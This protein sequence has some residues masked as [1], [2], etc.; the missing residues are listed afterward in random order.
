MQSPLTQRA[1]VATPHAATLRLPTLLRRIAVGL[2]GLAAT[3]GVVLFLNPSHVARALAG[4]PLALIAPILAL[5]ILTYVLAGISL[6]FPA[7][8]RRDPS[9][10]ARHDAAQHGGADHQ[11]DPAPGRSHPCRLRERRGKH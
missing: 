1:H 5:P 9:P 4:F 11:R 7:Q 8:G 10:R 3:V 2:L 6:A